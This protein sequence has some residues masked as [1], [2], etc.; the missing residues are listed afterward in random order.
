MRF[1][2][3]VVL[4]AACASQRT[5]SATYVDAPQVIQTPDTPAV[6]DA[7][8]PDYVGADVEWKNVPRVARFVAPPPQTH[9]GGPS[10][11]FEYRVGLQCWEDAIRA[12]ADAAGKHIEA[13]RSDACT[14]RTTS[15]ARA[16][17]DEE[18]RHLVWLVNL[19]EIERLVPVP[20]TALSAMLGCTDFGEAFTMTTP[21]GDASL[22][23][24]CDYTAEALRFV[25]AD[26]EALARLGTH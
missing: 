17:T 8:L 12:W 19:A 25:F 21:E 6:V 1:S 14:H 26:M 11:C 18:W 7:P 13:E 15:R 16:L 10:T 5:T 2:G 22:P 9:R 20:A 23:E 3:A 24:G 4:L